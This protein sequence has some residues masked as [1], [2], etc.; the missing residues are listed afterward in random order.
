VQ[1]GFDAVGEK[2][3]QERLIR[4]ISFVGKAFQIVQ[5]R[6]RLTSRR[7]IVCVDGFNLGKEG[8]SALFQSMK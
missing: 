7:E 4:D 3:F 6:V 1:F 2:G 8:V 5:A